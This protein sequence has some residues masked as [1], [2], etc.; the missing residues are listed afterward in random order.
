[1]PR[2][3]LFGRLDTAPVPEALAGHGR[4][5]QEG[6]T[7]MSSL[8]EQ[9]PPAAP[10]RRSTPKRIASLLQGVAI[11]VG[12]AML[13]GGVVLVAVQ[14]RPYRIPSTSMSPTIQVGDTV[15]ARKTDGGTVGRGDIVVFSEPLWGGATMVKR[16]A[17]L[18]GDTVA[19][20]DAGQRLT[21]NGVGV[22]ESYA[23]EKLG[24][25]AGFS[26]TVPEGRLFLLGDSRANSLDS[27][28]HLDVASGTVAASDVVARVEAIAWPSDRMASVP[29]ADA[30]D[31]IAGRPAS[32]H[33]LLVPAT[34]AAVGGALL[35]LA[36]GAAGGIAG[37][38]G[39]L[40]GRRRT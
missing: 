40:L 33:G 31:A 28:S 18:G 24:P 16:V 19:C 7:A 32:R 26:I 12:F 9:R 4:A 39:R 11:A 10:V 37:L 5:D 15:L 35:V 14:Y 3:A 22:D 36:A 1:M 25:G 27:R 30:F 8:T 2:L 23:D 6:T 34:Y 29:R 17:A 20:C 13:V 38:A 21:V